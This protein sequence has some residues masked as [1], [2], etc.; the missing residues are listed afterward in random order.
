MRLKTILVPLLIVLFLL[1]LG[2]LFNGEC[3]YGGGMAAAYKVCECLGIEWELYDQ[4][5]ADGPRKTI[6]TGIVQSTECHRYIGG[7]R[8][9][10]N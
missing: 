8:V 1:A 6:C 2:L 10:C 4:T 7:P 5:A 3:S 9:A